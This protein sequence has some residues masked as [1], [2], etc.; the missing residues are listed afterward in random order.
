MVHN[1]RELSDAWDSVDRARA[2]VEGFID[3][4][5]E[6][7][8]IVA[9]NPHGHMECFDIV[10]NQ[11]ANHILDVTIAPARIGADI[12][13]KA[14]NTGTAIAEA[15]DLVGLVAV[16]MFVTREGD[17]LVNEIAPRPHNSGHWTIDSCVTSQFEQMVRAV[18]GL[19][20]GSSARHSNA[21]MRNLIGD[22]AHGW[23]EILESPE[24]KLH[25]YGKSEARPGRKMGHMTRLYSK[26]VEWSPDEV[27]T[28]LKIWD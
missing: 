14:I 22:D 26:A 2:V 12:A 11:H 23:G 21:I 19:P 8:V 27:E 13:R 25:L 17:I 9:R 18:C 3:F 20:L 16:E 5:C 28:A 10:E 1:Q 4:A 7:S 15:L 24:T 6:V